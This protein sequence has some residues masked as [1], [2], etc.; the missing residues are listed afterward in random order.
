MFDVFRYSW[1]RIQARLS[2]FMQVQTHLS[3]RADFKRADK[4]Y[5]TQARLPLD[6][7]CLDWP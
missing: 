2:F 7:T 6:L 3:G 5:N 1:H 4:R